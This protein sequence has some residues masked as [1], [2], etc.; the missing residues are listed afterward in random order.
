[1]KL[2]LGLY[3]RM[4]TVEKFRFAR[5][6]GATHIVAHLTDYFKDS[7]SLSTAS[8]G[9][10]W[11]ITTNQAR[12]WSYEE[13]SDLRRA[14]E[15]EGLQLAA[16]ENFDPAHWGDHLGAT[17]LPGIAAD[18]D[19]NGTVEQADWSYWNARFGNIVVAQS[20]AGTVPEPSSLLLLVISSI[21]LASLHRRQ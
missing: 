20:G 3:R 9:E 18:G 10:V 13:L 1:M 15:T 16:L 4:L 6:A 5:Q 11:G 2:G 19:N 12:L 17:G 7:E 21:A 8:A 14:I